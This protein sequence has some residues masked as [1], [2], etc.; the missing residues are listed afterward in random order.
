MT[1]KSFGTSIVTKN[2]MC[3][4]LMMT[5]R[6][7]MGG[8]NKRGKIG[9]IELEGVE[10]S[11]NSIVYSTSPKTMKMKGTVNGQEVVVL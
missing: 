8:R 11:M 2:Y 10:L 5:L 9:R 3:C 7:V 6:W 1:N 4:Q